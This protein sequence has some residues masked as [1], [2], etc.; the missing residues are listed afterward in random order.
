MNLIFIPPTNITEKCPFGC[1][2]DIPRFD[3]AERVK[4]VKHH[5]LPEYLMYLRNN[6]FYVE[7]ARLNGAPDVH[8]NP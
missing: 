1:G 5:H 2:E 3:E 8:N 6:G 7:A 4:H